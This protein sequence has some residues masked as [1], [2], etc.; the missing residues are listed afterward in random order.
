MQSVCTPMRSLRITFHAQKHRSEARPRLPAV[1]FEGSYIQHDDIAQ[2]KAKLHELRAQFVPAS[3]SFCD[4]IR[5][6]YHLRTR[7]EPPSD[8]SGTSDPTDTMYCPG[9]APKKSSNLANDCKLQR[10]DSLTL[11]SGASREATIPT[12]AQ[13]RRLGDSKSDSGDNGDGGRKDD[14]HT[15]NSPDTRHAAP[16]RRPTRLSRS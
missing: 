3:L 15:L 4:P 8:E 10:I 11:F 5:H 1:E 14:G 16:T 2:C 13:V 7:T 9:L 12:N 6:L